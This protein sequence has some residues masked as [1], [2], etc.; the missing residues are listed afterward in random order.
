MKVGIFDIE[1]SPATAH[2]WTLWGANVS[3]AQLLEPSR[4]LSFAWAWDDEPGVEFFSE[5][6]DGTGVMRD[7]L[8]DRLSEA[9]AT[10][11][12]NGKKFD[13][14]HVRRELLE[15][16]YPPLKP[17][18]P[19]DLMLEV[20][21]HFAFQSNKLDYV[22]GQLL[23]SH[24]VSHE[25]HSL[26]VKCLEGDPKAWDTMR[27]YNV[28]DVRLTKKLYRHLKPYIGHPSIPLF[29]GDTDRPACDKGCGYTLE[30]RGVA[31]TKQSAFQQ[32]RC[33]KCGSWQ[34]DT[35]R[36]YGVSNVAVAT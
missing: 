23:G 25:G 29:D 3:L 32:Y 1:T 28:G 12:W 22:A 4:V 19:I 20:R 24:K 30:K 36:L 9:D 18:V 2:V 34:R 5:Y 7:A 8:Y 35:Q 10:V 27:R 13:L 17:S 16:G 6:H 15:G 31:R 11:T 26:W 21:K 14:K 33:R